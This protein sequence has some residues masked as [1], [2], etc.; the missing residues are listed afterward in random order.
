MIS[1]YAPT[2]R[3]V[4]HRPRGDRLHSTQRHQI[5][6][7]FLPRL[8]L[9]E[10]LLEAR[11]DAEGDH[12]RQQRGSQSTVRDKLLCGD[13]CS[14]K[15]GHVHAQ[16]FRNRRWA[17]ALTD[18]STCAGSCHATLARHTLRTGCGKHRAMAQSA[19]ALV[20]ASTSVSEVAGTVRNRDARSQKRWCTYLQE[21]GIVSHS[22]AA[23]CAQQR[24]SPRTSWLLWQMAIK[25]ARR[26]LLA[27]LAESSSSYGLGTNAGINSTC[28]S[29]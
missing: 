8:G 10:V 7:D 13:V 17:P 27:E 3:P 21:S 25:D 6:V 23:A 1:A 29:G 28:V 11:H 14:D 20:A 5:C 18:M 2:P 22:V 9:A 12:E 19:Q 24:L 4:H 16:G 26:S 15:A